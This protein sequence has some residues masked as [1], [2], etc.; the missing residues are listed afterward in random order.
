MQRLQ[1]LF[2]YDE[3]EM[4][5]EDVVDI[6]IL[7]EGI[8]LGTFTWY[9]NMVYSFIPPETLSFISLDLLN[10]LRTRVSLE[11]VDNFCPL[12]YMQNLEAEKEV[13]NRVYEVLF[14]ALEPLPK[15]NIFT[16][17]Q[18]KRTYQGGVFDPGGAFPFEPF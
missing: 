7:A 1:E 5:I 2:H 3:A 10:P 15:H 18:L 9:K 16:F 6:D 11:L 14:S 8:P 17:V 13:L 12:P 4:P